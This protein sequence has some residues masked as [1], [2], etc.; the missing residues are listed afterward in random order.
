MSIWHQIQTGYTNLHFWWLRALYK[1]AIQNKNL[2]LRSSTKYCTNA[3]N[4]LK[5]WLLLKNHARLSSIHK[6]A[7]LDTKFFWY[8]YHVIWVENHQNKVYLFTG[9]PV[10][11]SKC[12][13]KMKAD[14]KQLMKNTVWSVRIKILKMRPKNVLR[15]GHFC[16]LSSIKAKHIS[17]VL[18]LFKNAWKI[19]NMKLQI[20]MVNRVV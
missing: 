17:K 19:V 13:S 18:W 2:H 4:P 14:F 20:L 7:S 12:F 1:D 9:H 3:N 8:F 15:Y 6:P 5:K 11:I 16:K 10:W